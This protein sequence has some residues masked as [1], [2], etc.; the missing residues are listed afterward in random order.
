[1]KKELTKAEL[2]V[3]QVIWEIKKGFLRNIVENF[4]DPK[5]APTTVSTILRILVEKGFVGFKSQNRSNEYYPKVSKQNYAK[6]SIKRVVSS[7]FDNSYK[8]FA[9]FFT[10]DDDLSIEELESLKHQIELQIEEKKSSGD[11]K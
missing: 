6:T 4:P 9:S 3:M 1:M 8:Q 10:S 7:F 11:K 5:P 2:Q